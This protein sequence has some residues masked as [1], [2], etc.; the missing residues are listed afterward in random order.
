MPICAGKG[1]KSR[2]VLLRCPSERDL[3]HYV[4]SLPVS[5]PFVSNKKD[6]YYYCFSIK[7]K[8]QTTRDII[9]MDLVG[10]KHC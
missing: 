2:T 8:P 9:E 6:V 5:V 4:V 7:K 10:P 3:N 1:G